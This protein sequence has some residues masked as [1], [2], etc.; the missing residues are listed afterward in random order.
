MD[1][2]NSGIVVA[3]ALMTALVTIPGTALA[4]HN[5]FGPHVQVVEADEAKAGVDTPIDERGE[6]TPDIGPNSP[7][8]IDFHRNLETGTPSMPARPAPQ[9]QTGLRYHGSSC[10]TWGEAVGD[11]GTATDEEEQAWMNGLETGSSCYVGFLDQQLEYYIA[12]TLLIAV[13]DDSFYAANP[14]EGD[15]YCNG[16]EDTGNR[17]ISG[18]GPVEDAADTVIVGDDST[19]DEMIT[20]G[21]RADDDRCDGSGEDKQYWPGTVQV[22]VNLLEQGT[23]AAHEAGGSDRGSGT[24]S[25]PVSGAT[26]AYVF[27]QPHPNTTGD[28]RSG[29]S[30]GQGPFGP[31]G[32]GALGNPIG[33]ITG[34]C[35]D[36]TKACELLSPADV[37]AYDD[38]FQE[39]SDKARVCYFIPQYR[40]S[41]AGGEGEQDRSAGVC[42][43]SGYQAYD[44]IEA[45]TAGGLGTD[46]PT[47]LHT[48]P[49]WRYPVILIPSE[50]Y[51][52]IVDVMSEEDPHSPKPPGWDDTPPSLVRE[53]GLAQERSP[54][55]FVQDYFDEEQ[56]FRKGFQA[57]VA[58]NPYVPTREGTLR[59]ITPNI[60]ADGD[61][62][63]LPDGFEGSD[64]GVYGTY[65]ADAIDA[66]VYPVTMRQQFVGVRD[67]T[68]EDV[69][70]GPDGRDGSLPGLAAVQDATGMDYPL[71]W[72][73]ETTADAGS[74]IDTLGVP[75]E[76]EYRESEDPEPHAEYHASD[77]QETAPTSINAEPFLDE[78]PAGLQCD[79]AGELVFND[80]TVE[81]GG[82]MQFDVN[83]QRAEPGADYPD[84]NIKDPTLGVVAE[85]DSDAGAWQPDIYSFGGQAH[86]VVDSNENQRFDDCPGSNLEPHEDVCPWEAIWDAYNS[87]CN[88]IEA[89]QTCEDVLEGFGYNV[90]RGVG[91][92]SVLKVTG[93]VA[94]F[95]E[96]TT[97]ADSSV[98]RIVVGGTEDATAKNCVIGVSTGF[99]HKLA[100]FVGPDRDDPAADPPQTDATWDA[101]DEEALCGTYTDTIETIDDA[102]DDQSAVTPG[103]FS[104][105]IQWAKLLPTPAAVQEGT[106]FGA[107]DQLCVEGIWTVADTGSGTQVAADTAEDPEDPGQ[108]NIVLEEGV[109]RFNDCDTFDTIG[110]PQE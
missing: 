87:N 103:G 12:T 72:A 108:E 7:F 106:G 92:Y 88:T 109:H 110:Q 49:G 75:G 1:P 57:Y 30:A 47:F 60:L 34:A 51:D 2:R 79:A 81:R 33:D 10:E 77:Y 17:S 11:D 58:V 93:P 82:G 20:R 6:L 45:A 91:L 18:P 101:E 83:L 63:Q 16:R 70:Y 27:G 105:A 71:P 22:D 25:L 44:Y 86:A 69:R 73:D 13:Q 50:M 43:N 100:G 31:V 59:C 94:V 104:A 66:D 29:L 35:G 38:N 36:R 40:F 97:E 54:D 74:A 32:S 46:V 76:L 37:K 14:E 84:R 53:D 64:P 96:A 5:S 99:Q 85:G 24:W 9:D 68:H 19:V 21:S 78:V 90:T 98:D 107:D 8:N 15:E 62:S 55:G 39:D 52:G 28:E 41:P 102:F 3:V 89:E 65:L 4:T 23:E 56:R 95:S 80:Q 67:E 26:Y 42:G 61:D 48:L